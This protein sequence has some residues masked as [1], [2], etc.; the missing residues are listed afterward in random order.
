MTD[1]TKA[2]E[3]A[4]G[5]PPPAE[6]IPEEADRL[7]FFVE[8]EEPAPEAEPQAAAPHVTPG[9][10]AEISGQLVAFAAASLK[11]AHPA[12]EYDDATQTRV[13]DALTP[14]VI[15]YDGALP[16]WLLK[17]KEEIIL[18][19]VLAS[20]AYGS[21]KAVKDYNAAAQARNDEKKAAQ[22]EQAAA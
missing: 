11:S 15:K 7:L 16:P 6:P 8:G 3:P 2:E 13:R 22:R 17:W 10:A 1:K 19:G 21:V 4:P 9:E 20:V 14:V 18:C 5:T 12:L